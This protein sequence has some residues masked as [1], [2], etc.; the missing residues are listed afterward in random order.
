M[1]TCDPLVALLDAF[2]I[3]LSQLAKL[4]PGWPWGKFD[5]DVNPYFDELIWW[6]I[7]VIPQAISIPNI[8]KKNWNCTKIINIHIYILY[9]KIQ[10]PLEVSLQHWLIYD[11]GE[12]LG[13]E[14]R[15]NSLPKTWSRNHNC[16][17]VAFLCQTGQ[18]RSFSSNSL[19]F[20]AFIILRAVWSSNP[21]GWGNFRHA[22]WVCPKTWHAKNLWLIN[23]CCPSMAMNG[24]K[25]PIFRHALG[26][27]HG[28]FRTQI[29]FYTLQFGPRSTPREP[30][31]TN[32]VLSCDGHGLCLRNVI[33]WIKS[34]SWRKKTRRGSPSILF[35]SLPLAPFLLW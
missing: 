7:W 10:C 29:L 11:K 8:S 27:G 3:L 26:W 34:L 1:S 28:L 24:G 14:D 21:T 31:T 4:L 12:S 5:P 19:A 20:W 13:S 15:R 9:T 16:W 22:S 32:L 17:E 18:A 6:Y 25:S 23:W 35:I 2:G 33:H 30:L